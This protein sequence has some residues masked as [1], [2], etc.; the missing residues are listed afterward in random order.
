AFLARG[1][2]VRT[3]VVRLGIVL[4]RDGG[5]YPQMSKPFRWFLGATL[6]QGYAWMSWIHAAD[7]TGILLHLLDKDVSG[8]FNATAPNPVSNAEFSRTLA[9][10]LHRPCFAMLPKVALRLLKGEFAKVITASTRVKPLRT[11][12]SGYAFRFPRL[13]EALENLEA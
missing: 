12:A 2:G 1:G 5:A 10:V 8:V 9:S 7:V 11:E 6:G 13:R 4:G 3:A